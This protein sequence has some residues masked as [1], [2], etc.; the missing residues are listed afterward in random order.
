M[1]RII[2]LVR[3]EKLAKKVRNSITFLPQF[4]TKNRPPGGQ[5]PALDGPP[6][7]SYSLVRDLPETI[8]FPVPGRLSLGWG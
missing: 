1:G 6:R 7:P 5:F 4:T 2:C 8:G 3:R